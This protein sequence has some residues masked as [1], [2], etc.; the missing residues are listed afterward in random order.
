MGGMVIIMEGLEEHE[1]MIF[2]D[3]LHFALHVKDLNNPAAAV[4]GVFR[5]LTY[6]YLICNLKP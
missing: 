1:S 5:I 6:N 3:T 2:Q 4:L